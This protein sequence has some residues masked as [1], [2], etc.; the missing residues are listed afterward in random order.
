MAHLTIFLDDGGVMNDNRPRAAQWQRLVGAFF[1]PLLGGMPE[2]WA[3]ANHVL[4]TGMFEPAAW[5]ARMAAATDYDDLDRTYW[6]DWLLGMCA[7]VGVPAPAAEDATALGRRASAWITPQVR[8]AYPGA[9]DAIR[10][11]HAAGYPLHT[12]SGESS[13]DLAGYLEGMGVRACFGRLYGPDL[14]N[15]LKAGPDYYVR[16]LADAGVDPATA[17][18]VDD[19]PAVMGWAATAGARAVLVSASPLADSLATWH[20]SALAD[21]P[22]LLARVE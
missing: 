2:A 16:L 12:A 18:F 10:A 17:L 8:T 15:T 5:Q 3:E 21:L 11:L 7:I 9:V 19:S 4:T 14:I 13:A 22:G 1:A 20:I 6:R